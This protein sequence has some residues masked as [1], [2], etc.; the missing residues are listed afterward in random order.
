MDETRRRILQLEIERQAL[1]KEE[2]DAS[3]DRLQR[4][5]KELADSRAEIGRASCRER[6]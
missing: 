2:D 5:E 1:K 3:A 4:L 6:V